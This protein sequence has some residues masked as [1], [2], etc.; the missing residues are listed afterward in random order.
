MTFVVINLVNCEVSSRENCG[1]ISL[2]F[3]NGTVESYRGEGK[4]S[5]GFVK[6]FCFR[7]H[8]TARS[9]G[10]VKKRALVWRRTVK[11][12]ILVRNWAAF[13]VC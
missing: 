6:D 10:R 7:Q 1:K 9:G 4:F 5:A 12:C 2:Y 11:S 8:K 13:S 3:D